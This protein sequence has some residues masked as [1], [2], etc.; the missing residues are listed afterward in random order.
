MLRNPNWTRLLCV[1][2]GQCSPNHAIIGADC[3]AHSHRPPSGL[4]RTRGLVT[5]ASRSSTPI[6]VSTRRERDHLSTTTR[7]KPSVL[8]GSHEDAA[9]FEDYGDYS[10][11]LPAEPFVFGTTHIKKRTVPNS[12]VR[13]QK[14]YGDAQRER[15]RGPPKGKQIML[16]G[17]EEV[18]LRRAAALAKRVREYAGSLVKVRW[19]SICMCLMLD[20]YTGRMLFA[21]RW[22]LQRTRLTRASML[23]L[24]PTARIRPRLGILNFQSRVVRGM[25]SSPFMSDWLN[26]EQCQ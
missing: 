22:A 21:N 12:I 20:F 3:A 17:A 6:T 2:H 7:V 9:E 25:S 18:R 10:V 8:A 13:P 24:L 14:G 23:L 5:A 26:Q 19:A 16:G 15:N 4:R 11:I 1:L